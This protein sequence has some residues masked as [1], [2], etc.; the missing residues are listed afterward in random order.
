MV[1]SSH[2]WQVGTEIEGMGGLGN[3][4]KRRSC[5][6]KENRMQT[7]DGSEWMDQH[8]NHE[9]RMERWTLECR[10][11]LEECQDGLRS[12][13]TDQGVPRRIEEYQDGLRSAKRDQGVPRRIKECQ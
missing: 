13:R 1:H 3:G 4:G 11:E 10:H 6:E 2:G 5:E 9:K 12:V 7:I 8:P